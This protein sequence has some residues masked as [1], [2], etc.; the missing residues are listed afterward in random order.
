MFRMSITSVETSEEDGD[1]KETSS[2][3]GFALSSMIRLT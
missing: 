3:L 1:W 2:S